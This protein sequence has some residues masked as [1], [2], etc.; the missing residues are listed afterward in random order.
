MQL[1]QLQSTAFI[2]S[3]GGPINPI[4]SIKSTSKDLREDELTIMGVSATFPH[5]FGYRTPGISCHR[6]R[7]KRKI[8]IWKMIN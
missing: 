3:P 4:I 1:I 8:W 5:R 2:H 7:E 6:R